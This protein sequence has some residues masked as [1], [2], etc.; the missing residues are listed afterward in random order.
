LF[1]G[2]NVKIKMSKTYIIAEAGVNHNGNIDI[3]L[4]L[5]DAAKEAGADC[6]KF[7]TFKA[8]Q[9]VT[10]SSPKAEYQLK[11]TDNTEN[12]FEMLKKLE[13]DFVDYS[14]I[15]KRCK[16]VNIDFLSTPYNKEDVDFLVSLG[17]DGFKIASGQ[18]TELP[19]LRYAASKGK[20]MIISTRMATMADVFNAVV[21]IRSVGNENIVVLQCTTNY[22][23]R[24]ED[25]NILAMLSMKEA[26]KVSVGYSDH[27]EN[28]YACFAAVALGAEL[29]E[30]HFT[31][32]KNME[33]PDHSSSLTKAEF[34]ELVNGIRNIELCLGSGLK[35]P[36]SIEE[37]NIY[38]MKR[39]LVVIKDVEKG[40]VITE[41][42]IGF[43]RPSNG[44]TVNYLDNIIGKTFAKAMVK[45]EAL[46]Y[47]SIVW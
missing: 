37:K 34:G 9:I 17:V 7:Q 23:S 45:D 14:V 22:P 19:F 1:Y 13:L 43:K 26:C 6:V 15:L 47:S 18:L 20:K 31:L 28:N 46:Q 8:D 25:A 2:F 5:V 11:V 35:I 12:Q 16:E 24:I 41:D 27:V 38:G 33:G 40:S 21:A 30:K 32:A 3:A 10:K 42:L 39:S 36:S 44:L 29:V 4:K